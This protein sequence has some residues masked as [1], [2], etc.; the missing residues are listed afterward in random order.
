MQLCYNAEASP[1]NKKASI[2]TPVVR[3]S[4]VAPELL[5]ELKINKIIKLISF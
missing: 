2:Q 4:T 3:V 5:K 1:L